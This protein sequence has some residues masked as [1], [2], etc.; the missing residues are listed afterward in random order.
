MK[1]QKFFGILVVLA[2]LVALIPT[3]SVAAAVME[4]K[5]VCHY[6]K[7][8]GVFFVININENA[9]DSHLAHGDV[10]P[11]SP[12]PG[13]LGME[14]GADCSPIRVFADVNGTWSGHSGLLGSMTYDFTMTLTQVGTSVTGT[15]YYVNL[16]PR[17]VTGTVSGNT[18]TFTQ[19][20]GPSYSATVS[21]PVVGAYFHGTG[22]HTGGAAVELEA[23]KN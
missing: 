10:E 15:I 5:D 6:D 22:T 1:A 19:T 9:Y 20:N 8:A 17:P 21:G 4:K 16:D 14:Y 3:G 7:D 12:I 23:T 13:M 18:F 2:L 11:N